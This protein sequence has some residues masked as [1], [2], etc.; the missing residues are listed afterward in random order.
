MIPPFFLKEQP[1]GAYT[2]FENKCHPENEDCAIFAPIISI[3][4]SL[5][6]NKQRTISDKHALSYMEMRCFKT[7]SFHRRTAS[8]SLL[9]AFY[10]L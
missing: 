1:N 3:S 10:L 4:S 9:T 2:A 6:A 7:I 8:L 5:S